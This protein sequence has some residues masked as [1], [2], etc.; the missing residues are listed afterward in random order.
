[1]TYVISNDLNL[2]YQRFTSPG[3]TDI[4][5]RKLGFAAKTQ[6]KFSV[7]LFNGLK[8]PNS[9]DKYKT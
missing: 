1:M 7:D 2:K 8:K 6:F 3:C 5:I 9:E 4:G